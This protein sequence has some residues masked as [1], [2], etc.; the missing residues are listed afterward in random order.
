MKFQEAGNENHPWT[1]SWTEPNDVD[2][3]LMGCAYSSKAA[4][5][6]DIKSLPTPTATGIMEVLLLRQESGSFAGTRDILKSR[7]TAWVI[8]ASMFLVCSHWGRQ[9]VL[10]DPCCWYVKLSTSQAMVRPDW[11]SQYRQENSVQTRTRV[12]WIEMAL[13]S[14]LDTCEWEGIVLTTFCYTY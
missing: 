1:R 5:F 7:G 11:C 2:L 4:G 9:S 14:G 10:S 6:D 13:S 12:D 3:S 8:R